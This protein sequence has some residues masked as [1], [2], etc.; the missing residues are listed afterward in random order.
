[1][2]ID[3]F[4]KRLDRYY[5]GTKSYLAENYM[6]EALNESRDDKDYGSLLIVC[7]ELGGFYRA[8]GRYQDAE[9]IYV[10]AID[11]L[12][13][14][15]MFRSEN[16]ATTLINQATNYAVWGKYTESIE[17][18]DAAKFI[19]EDLG[20][21]VDFRIASLHN[22]MSIAY[23]DMKKYGEAAEHLYKAIE[24]LKQLQDTDIEVATSYTNLAQIKY[25]AQN[26]KEALADVNT[27]INLFKEAGAMKDIHYSVALETHGNICNKLHMYKEAL[28]SYKVASE[29]VADHFGTDHR[30]YQ[31][32]VFNIGKIERKIAIEEEM[33]Q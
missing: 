27:S 2:N 4:Y 1:M 19:L 18:F 14:I 3:R 9:P 25:L 5:S 32:L 22:N 6:L 13:K 12:R 23:Q 8:M 31:G 7:N 26:Y 24:I 29:I 21:K 30:G 28:E 33:N 16:H 10:E 15:G 11:A 17:I 20:I